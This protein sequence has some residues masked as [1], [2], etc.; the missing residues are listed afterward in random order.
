MTKKEKQ[1]QQQQQAFAACKSLQ[2]FVKFC[3]ILKKT[4]NQ[5]ISQTDKCGTDVRGVEE[6]EGEAAAAGFCCTQKFVKLIEKTQK[7]SLTFE[8]EEEQ[9]EEEESAAAATWR[10][11]R[12]I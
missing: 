7:N 5:T 9:E 10:L 4:N 1:Q 6:R 2:K 3:K 12:R 11:A 8:E